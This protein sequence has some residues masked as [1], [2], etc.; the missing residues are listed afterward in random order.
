MRRPDQT[1]QDAASTPEEVLR[2]KLTAC[3]KKFSPR[4]DRC[5]RETVVVASSWGLHGERSHLAY[6]RLPSHVVDEWHEAT[7]PTPET[8]RANMKR[9]LACWCN[10]LLRPLVLPH[11]EHQFDGCTDERRRIYIAAYLRRELRLW[12][13]PMLLGLCNRSGTSRD[14]QPRSRELRRCDTLVAEMWKTALSSDSRASM[15][16][17]W[18]LS[19]WLHDRA[20]LAHHVRGRRGRSRSSRAFSGSAA[21][22]P[23]VQPRR[24]RPTRRSGASARCR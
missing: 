4:M 23:W 2:V 14:A 1:A 8:R 16:H 18:D 17:L 24:S 9:K 10:G 20:Q 15:G 7:Y 6:S 11:A 19:R 21:T 12:G 22:D 5:R 13:A 3:G